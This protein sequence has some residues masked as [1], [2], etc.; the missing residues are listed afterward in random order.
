MIEDTIEERIL[1]LQ[2]KKELVF[3][4]YDFLI[5]DDSWVLIDY[6]S[7]L[8]VLIW[9]TGPLVILKMLFQS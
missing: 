5:G 6:L 3:E 8:H 9:Y 4:G 1:K 2:Q 7:W